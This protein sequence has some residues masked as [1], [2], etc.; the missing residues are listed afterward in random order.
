MVTTRTA[1]LL[2]IG[3]EWDAREQ[4]LAARLDLL[5]L[6]PG[7]TRQKPTTKVPPAIE[8]AIRAG[9]TRIGR[10]TE[11]IQYVG[12]ACKAAWRNGGPRWARG[13]AE[14]GEGRPAVSAA[15]RAACSGA[16]E[17]LRGTQGHGSAPRCGLHARALRVRG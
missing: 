6:N 11:S 4:A 8:R 10:R 14:E 3:S 9:A 5:L 16:Q 13:P 1:R 7:E 2:F 12:V 17:A 15:G